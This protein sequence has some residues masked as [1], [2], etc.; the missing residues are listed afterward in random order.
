MQTNFE[1]IIKS[2]LE[3]YSKTLFSDTSQANNFFMKYGIGN[4]TLE[5]DMPFERFLYYEFFL[6]ELMNSDYAKYKRMH[7]GIPFYFLAWLAFDFRNYEKALYYI[8]AAISED[9]KNAE[10]NPFSLPA[11][12]FLLLNPKEQVA[13][14]TIEIIRST[15]DEELSRFNAISSETIQSIEVLNSHFVKPLLNKP[16]NRTIISAFYVFLLEYSERQKEIRMRSTEGGSIA[17]FI[18]HLFSGALIFESIL[19]SLFPLKDDHT[20][21]QTLGDIFITSSFLKLYPADIS[22]SAFSFKNILAGVIDESLLTAFSITSKIRN[23]TGHNLIWDDTFADPI[24]YRTLFQQEV[25]SILY[26]VNKSFL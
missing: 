3:E 25:N 12:N 26:I 13:K 10:E 16:R 5:M 17:P 22:T 2:A 15:L 4:T 6:I 11:S 21:V 7:K 20:S 19:K 24:N 1:E 9:V 14:R 8:D 23:T 18:N